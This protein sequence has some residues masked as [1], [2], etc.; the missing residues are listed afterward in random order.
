MPKEALKT[1]MVNMEIRNTVV[2]HRRLCS[3]GNGVIHI[4]SALFATLAVPYVSALREAPRTFLYHESSP[5]IASSPYLLITVLQCMHKIR[6]H[7]G[8]V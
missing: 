2:T 4:L 6:L 1:R 3:P 7:A 5:M 8:P